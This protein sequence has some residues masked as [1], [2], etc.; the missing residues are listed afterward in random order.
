MNRAGGQGGEQGGEQGGGQV[1][2]QGEWTGWL[3][4]AGGG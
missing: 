1:G 4:M 3:N 2:E